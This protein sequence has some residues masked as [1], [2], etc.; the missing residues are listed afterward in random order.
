MTLGFQLPRDDRSDEGAIGRG[1]TFLIIDKFQC[2][3]VER[4]DEQKP[5]TSRQCSKMF[6][7]NLE[8]AGR[9]YVRRYTYGHVFSIA[10][11][12]KHKRS[13]HQTTFTDCSIGQGLQELNW[14]TAG[15]RADPCRRSSVF[16]RPHARKYNPPICSNS[17]W[18]SHFLAPPLLQYFHW[19]LQPFPFS[20]SC[21]F[22]LRLPMK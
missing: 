1:G 9:C 12:A 5:S 17:L 19:A 4:I 11:N 7:S 6:G 8:R 20:P 22:S 21:F 10:F 14:G 16:Q 3:V 13:N 15:H 18:E 2:S